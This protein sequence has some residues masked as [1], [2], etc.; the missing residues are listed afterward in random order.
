M[1]VHACVYVITLKAKILKISFIQMA[2]IKSSGISML[3]RAELY[4]SYT[5]TDSFS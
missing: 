3:V 1:C 4:P 2:S 5:W